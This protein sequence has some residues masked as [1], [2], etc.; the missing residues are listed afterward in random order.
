MHPQEC[1][2]EGSQDFCVFCTYLIR[3]S[4]KRPVDQK[5]SK[6]VKVRLFV[7]QQMQSMLEEIDKDSE[8]AGQNVTHWMP[9]RLHIGQPQPV[10]LG[11]DEAASLN[12]VVSPNEHG[13]VV[14]IEVILGDAQVTLTRDRDGY[15]LYEHPCPM[16]E[17]HHIEG[18]VITFNVTEE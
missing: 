17:S 16:N 6:D 15:T 9:G 11:K 5:A 14:E 13:F 1:I 3:L 12:L 10:R 7:Q 4:N 2:E 8:R 18:N